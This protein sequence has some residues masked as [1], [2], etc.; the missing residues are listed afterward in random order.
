[1]KPLKMYM[2][3]DGEPWEGACLIFATNAK[4]ARRIGWST[5]K[6]WFDTEWIYMKVKWLKDK[7]FLR[8]EQTSDQ[9]HVIEQPTL[10]D[11]CE[12]WGTSLL[13]EQGICDDCEG[14]K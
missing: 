7:E 5:V 13:N 9:P 6:D 14:E 2:G 12:L 10:C 3:Y 11:S 8:S 1:M 4:E